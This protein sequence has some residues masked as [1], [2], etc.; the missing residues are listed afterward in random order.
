MAFIY[1]LSLQIFTY[2]YVLFYTLFILYGK[3]DKFL[4]THKTNILIMSSI[5]SYVK[6][7]LPRTNKL[8]VI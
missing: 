5:H 2:T 6:V 3:K 7:A 8:Q 1:F 4:N